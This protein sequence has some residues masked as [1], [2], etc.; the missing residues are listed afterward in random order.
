MRDDLTISCKHCKCFQRIAVCC[1]LSLVED[2]PARK[3]RW[4]S[5]AANSA[6]ETPAPLHEIRTFSPAPQSRTSLRLV[7]S[8]LFAVCGP[9]DAENWQHI[10]PGQRRGRRP[11]LRALK[12]WPKNMGCGNIDARL[13]TLGQFKSPFRHCE[14]SRRR[15][16]AISSMVA[17]YV[18]EIATSLAPLVPRDD[19]EGH[20]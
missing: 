15:S 9:R 19:E 20:T 8:P 2:T 18:Q 5:V 6:G 12:V 4:D 16:A 1:T 10:S 3:K 7:H 17:L 14:R 13:E 11:P